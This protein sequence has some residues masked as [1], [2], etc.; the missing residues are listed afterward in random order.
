MSEPQ[1]LG[2]DHSLGGNQQF[3]LPAISATPLR[4]PDSPIPE[5]KAPLGKFT[6]ADAGQMHLYLNYAR[7]H[8]THEGENPPAPRVLPMTAKPKAKRPRTPPLAW[9][10]TT[11]QATASKQWSAD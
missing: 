8:W 7:E 10:I 5:S 4:I 3:P 9:P 1:P 6:H 11:S 2:Y